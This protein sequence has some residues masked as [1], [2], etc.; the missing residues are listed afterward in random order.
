MP[1]QPFQHLVNEG[2]GEIIF[3]GGLI[4]SMVINTQLPPGHSPSQNELIALIL[5]DGYPAL[6][7]DYLN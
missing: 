3:L 4:Q 6:F 5:N 2:E 7:G 1:C